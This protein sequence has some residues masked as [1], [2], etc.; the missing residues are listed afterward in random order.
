MK[1]RNYLDF[2]ISKKIPYMRDVFID[3]VF[4]AAKKIKI[5]ISQPQIWEHHL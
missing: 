1:K 4:F 5:Y 2:S 3:E